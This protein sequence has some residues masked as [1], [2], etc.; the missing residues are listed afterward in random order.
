MA[1]RRA[2][3][4]E[5]PDR[6]NGAV[7]LP[8]GMV[9]ESIPLAAL[10]K[11][12]RNVRLHPEA[13]IKEFMRAVEMFGQTRPVVVD[14]DNTVLVGNGLVMAMQ[15][16]ERAQ[17]DVLRKTGLSQSAKDKLML[18]DNKIFTLG[19]DDYDS[20]MSMIRG[21]DDLDIPGYDGDLLEGLMGNEDL[22]G[23]ALEGFGRMS[24][25]ERQARENKATGQVSRQSGQTT[26]TCP[27]CGKEFLIS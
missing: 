19:H 27:H 5:A 10:K 13:Q 4:A 14:E 22:A 24:E 23:D 15:R 26:A 9:I 21:L 18:S 16:L 25:E 20:I 8:P 6:V 3:T 17:I 12:A 1:A 11:P 2:R 7:A